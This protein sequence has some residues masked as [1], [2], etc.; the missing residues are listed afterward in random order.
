[1]ADLSLQSDATEVTVTWQYQNHSCLCRSPSQAIV[2]V[3]LESITPAALA[4]WCETQL[5]ALFPDEVKGLSLSFAPEPTDGAFYHYSHGLQQHDGNCQRIAHGHRSKIQIFL[6]GERNTGL[7]AQ[8]AAKFNDIYIG[9]RSH[10][11][12][13]DNAAE[14]AF[15][16]Q[17]PQGEFEI[18]LP[19][20]VCYLID[21]ETTVEQIAAHLADEIKNAHPDQKVVVRAFEGVGKGAIAER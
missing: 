15:L 21:T 9:T 2:P 12:A 1:M 16:Y 13:T 6:D 8:W 11:M 10:L 14:Y 18:R 7:E 5:M 20:S 17:A 3:P 4:R 19:H